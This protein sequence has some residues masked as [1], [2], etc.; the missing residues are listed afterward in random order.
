M[1]LWARLSMLRHPHKALLHIGLL[2]ECC[3][4]WGSYGLGKALRSSGSLGHYGRCPWRPL[5]EGRGGGTRRLCRKVALR[6]RSLRHGRRRSGRSDHATRSSLGALGLRGSK[7]SCSWLLLHHRTLS[8][9][10][11][12]LA[13]LLATKRVGGRRMTRGLN[14]GHRRWPLDHLALGGRLPPGRATR[15]RLG[16]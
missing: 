14:S 1:N 10:V 4:S 15:S 3:S 7:L 11:E 6:P 8:H 13:G 12:H 16:L 9:G 5:L 2:A